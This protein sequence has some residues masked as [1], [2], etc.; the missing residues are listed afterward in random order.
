MEAVKR[1]TPRPPEVVPG[2]AADASSSRPR[3]APHEDQDDPD[4]RGRTKK[5]ATPEKPGAGRVTPLGRQMETPASGK[6][7]GPSGQ[8]A[9]TQEQKKHANK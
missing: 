2:R 6:T 9:K 5:L 7:P 3:A 1:Q 8:R 4:Q